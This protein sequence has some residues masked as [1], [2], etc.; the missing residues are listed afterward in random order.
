MAKSSNSQCHD[1]SKEDSFLVDDIFTVHPGGT[2]EEQV[3][4]DKSRGVIHLLF[5]LFH[6][7]SHR[8]RRKQ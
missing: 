8:R 6:H 1:K 7:R 2:R 4:D 3:W 5:G